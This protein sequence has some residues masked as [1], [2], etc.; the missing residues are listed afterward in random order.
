MREFKVKLK[1]RDIGLIMQ[2]GLLNRAR[3]CSEAGTRTLL[4]HPVSVDLSVT[5]KVSLRCCGAWTRTRITRVRISSATQLHHPASFKNSLQFPSSR[6]RLQ[7]SFPLPSF[8]PGF[9]FFFMNN[10]PWFV[11]FCIKAFPGI[12][13]SQP[14]D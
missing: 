6:C 11:S 9:I 13:F 7:K 10:L 14:C 5:R 4:G 8:H 2:L 3:A 1:T 12:M